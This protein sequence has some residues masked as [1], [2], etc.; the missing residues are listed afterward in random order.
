M[1]RAESHSRRVAKPPLVARRR[2]SVSRRSPPHF[3]Q[4]SLGRRST[5]KRRLQTRNAGPP[6]SRYRR[7]TPSLP[8]PAG[9]RDR[10][11]CSLDARLSVGAQLRS[12]GRTLATPVGAPEAPAAVDRRTLLALHRQCRRSVGQETREQEGQVPS[13][14]ELLCCQDR[15]DVIGEHGAIDDI[16]KVTLEAARALSPALSLTSFA[17]EVGSRRWRTRAPE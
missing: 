5:Q 3:G 1:A 7:C 14:T 8:R 13:R 11:S 9:G 4:L 10:A 6:P 15:L 16:G 12:E 17:L 2:S